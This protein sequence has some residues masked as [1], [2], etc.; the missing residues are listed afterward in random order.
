MYILPPGRQGGDLPPAFS[1][2]LFPLGTIWLFNWF[3]IGEK[4]NREK[5]L[6]EKP[7]LAERY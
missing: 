5:N 1:P 3:V 6:A 7:P 2:Q 4:K